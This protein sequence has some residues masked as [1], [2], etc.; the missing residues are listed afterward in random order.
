MIKLTGEQVLRALSLY[1]TPIQFGIESAD[2]VAAELNK[3]LAADR[4]GAGPT[5]HKCG[6]LVES[7]DVLCTTHEAEI[8]EAIVKDKLAAQPIPEVIRSVDGAER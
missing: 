8:I 1:A 3:L 5:C 2:G 6:V 4:E 7:G